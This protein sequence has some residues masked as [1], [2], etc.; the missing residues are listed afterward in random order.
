VQQIAR[1]YA[2][3][4]AAEG[5]T[6]PFNLQLRRHADGRLFGQEINLRQTGSTMARFLLGLDEIHE[7]VAAFLPNVA[8]PK[9]SPGEAG[10]IDRV[11]KRYRAIP[12]SD[13]DVETLRETGHWNSP[14][15]TRT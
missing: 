5:A 12:I 15:D 9:L 7:T 6:G 13:K 1:R 2:E 10:R 11:V 3:A 14:V 4:I 8:F